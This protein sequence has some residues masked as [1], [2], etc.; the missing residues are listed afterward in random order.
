MDTLTAV[1]RAIVLLSALAAASVPALQD[2]H[3]AA[4]SCVAAIKFD[5]ALYVHAPTQAPVVTDVAVPGGV[6]PGCDDTVVL[7]PNGEPLGEPEPDLPIDLR[8]VRG[9]PVALAVAQPG[10]SG[11][12]LAPGTL[13]ELPG[14]PL[15]R[16]LYGSR[17]E[18]NARRGGACGPRHVV[19]VSLP[20]TPAQG[21]W[22][23]AVTAAGTDVPVTVDSG[24]VVRGARKL[25]GHPVLRQ[26]DRLRI[27]G[28]R[29]GEPGTRPLVARRLRVIT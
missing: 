1:K 29:C 7:G 28:Q 4:A 23:S 14:H 18:P 10:L 25:A 20:E 24:T 16:Q 3:D 11:V 9:V 27:V 26:G 21:S 2:P 15:H 8:R 22:M 19:R 17:S 6:V 5:G 12:F 13:P